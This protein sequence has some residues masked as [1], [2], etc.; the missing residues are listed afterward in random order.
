MKET[1]QYPWSDEMNCAVTV[2]DTDGTIL[3]MN[4]KAKETFA[5]HGN[6]IG[7]NLFKCHN[8]A[9]QA[10]IRELLSTGSSNA[11]TIEKQGVKKVIYQTAWREDGVVR[12][13]VEI[14]MIVPM[15][16]PHYIRQ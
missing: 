12:G 15:E 4:T 5:K 1:S 16:M 2:C 9:S 14:S 7:E 6:L 11:Y 3:Y 13:L 8:E 10:K